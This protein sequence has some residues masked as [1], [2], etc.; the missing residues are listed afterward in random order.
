M[1]NIRVVFMGTPEFGLPVLEALYNNCTVV[2]VVCQPDKPSNRG[3]VIYSP[4][5]TFAMEKGLNV[6][7]PS[8][9]KNDYADIVLAKP[10]IIVTCAYGQIIP[11][12]IIDYPKYG[13]INV[14]GS[15]LPKYRGGAPIHRAIMEGDDKTGITIMTM[16]P[17][18]DAGDIISQAEIPILDTDTLGSIH[19]KLSVLG[20]DLL[21]Q[22]L[23]TII[24]GTAKYTKQK[25]EDVTYAWTIKKEDEHVDF[26]KTTRE[27]I[28]H[29]RGLNPYP[30]AYS[31]I[32]G[33]VIKF[34]ASKNGDGHYNDA[35]NGQIV[36]LYDDGIGVKTSNGEIVI[37]ELK[38]EGKKKMSA[39]DFMNGVVNKELLLGRMFE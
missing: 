21:I 12:E 28:N 9:I 29:I 7:Q 2:L 1:K 32:S 11:K 19:D 34:Y 30:G 4:I 22:T 38:L 18:M 26:S 36:K 14:H 8:N 27:I 33:K 3:N 39:K 6:F 5:K 24:N 35:V 17:K 16:A 13:C 15:L 25:E 23:P 31:M 37:T 20:K 10:D